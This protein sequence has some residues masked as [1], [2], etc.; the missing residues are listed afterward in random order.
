LSRFP[1]SAW[2]LLTVLLLVALTSSRA[3]LA[4]ESRPAYLEIDESAPG[5]YSVLWRTPVLAGSRLPIVLRFPENVHNLREPVIQELSDS[6]LERRWVDAGPQG[7]AGKR[8]EFAGLQLTI[9]DAV[10]RVKL[11]DGRNWMT[12][13]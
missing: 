6:L 11:L 8:V 7:L 10:V 2:R 3:A 5:R 13:A 12:I 9:T 1:G 4:H